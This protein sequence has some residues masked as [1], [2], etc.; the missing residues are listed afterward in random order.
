MYERIKLTRNNES[1]NNGIS[2]YQCGGSKGKSTIDHI[3][4][5]NE[6]ISYN[7]YLN[8]ETYIIFADAYK[9]FDKLKL[10][11]CI[12]DLYKIIGAKEAMNVYRLNEIGN[13]TIDTPLGKVGPIKV[14][15]IVRQ[16]TIIGPKLCCINTD[17]INNIGRKCITSIGPNIKVEMLTYVDDINFASSNAEQIKKAV[18]NLRCME[19]CKG[20]TFNTGKNKTEIMIVNKR[21]NKEYNNTKLSVKK[22]EIGITN[23]YKYLGEWYNEKGNHATAIK[24]K[25]EK[26]NYY[27]KQIK[28]YGNEGV[29]GKYAMLTR[30]KIYKTII[31][32]TIYHNIEAWSNINKTEMKELEEIQGIILKRV[33]EQRK[34]TPYMG[35]L[36]ELGIWTVEKQIEYK[37]I[38]LLHNILTS[39]YDRLIKDIIKDQIQTTWP[40]SWIE[41][42]KQICNKYSLNIDEIQTYTKKNLKQLLKS[43]INTKLNIEIQEL[44]RNKTKGRF[45]KE[46]SQ[47][48][49]LK[50]LNFKD[51]IMMIKI[52]LNMIETKCNYKNLFT[53]LKCEICKSKDDTTE[54][55]MEYCSNNNSDQSNIEKLSKPN[56]EVVNIIAKNVSTRESLGYR[57]KVCIEEE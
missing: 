48:E 42:V 34:T 33:C 25:K 19:K 51:C 28:I 35:L 7:K 8:K 9:C 15:N 40:G 29:I 54:H 6:I 31:I 1:I 13:A 5:L 53:D 24:K 55:L 47:K 3:M 4:T 56:K 11:N 17:K 10:K 52:R 44:S 26:I 20:F 39:E 37:K 16:G 22:G 30:L 12:I 45:I 18:A 46:Y 41:N 32:P 2:K 23:E 49:Y 21:K 38:M 43:K 50:E 57:I 14:N 36:A 27:I